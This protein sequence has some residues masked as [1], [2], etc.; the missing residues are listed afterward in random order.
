MVGVDG[1]Q[2]R[3]LRGLDGL[4]VEGA[5]VLAVGTF[6]VR[7]NS[8]EQVR[9]VTAVRS[10]FRGLDPAWVRAVQ[11]FTAGPVARHRPARG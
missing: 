11:P 10:A 1:Q 6:L 9:I 5:G 2:L 8:D 3:P 7:G 4:V